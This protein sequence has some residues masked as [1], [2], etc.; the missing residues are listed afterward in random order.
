MDTLKKKAVDAD[1]ICGWWHS[2]SKNSVMVSIALW[3]KVIAVKIRRQFKLPPF[4]RLD[5]LR[6]VFTSYVPA[7]FTLHKSKSVARNNVVRGALAWAHAFGEEKSTRE[8]KSCDSNCSDTA[9]WFRVV[10]FDRE[11]GYRGTRLWGKVWVS[12]EC[13]LERWFGLKPWGSGGLGFGGKAV[14]VQL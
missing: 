6:I 9:Y 4:S 13:V 14:V 5:L 2:G 8:D 11:R 7:A 1:A 12:C 3:R 10:C